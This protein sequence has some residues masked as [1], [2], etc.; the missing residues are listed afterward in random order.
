MRLRV[1]ILPIL[2]IAGPSCAQTPPP[3]MKLLADSA[4]TQ[5]LILKEKAE[6]KPGQAFVSEPLVVL[7]PYT[8]NLD[9]RALPGAPSVHETEAELFYVVEGRGTLTVGGTMTDPK[10]TN[11]TNLAGAGITG[12]TD[13]SLS[14]G[15]L[16]FVPQGVPHMW[17]PM[18][19]PVID[20]SLHVT[21]PLP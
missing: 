20:L 5:A 12:G 21:R 4:S 13:Y 2:L 8:V 15:D 10:R 16:F 7:A 14:K 18:G 3:P 17:V 6:I 1:L 19:G 11:A 9:Y